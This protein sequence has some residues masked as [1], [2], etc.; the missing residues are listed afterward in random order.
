M[1]AMLWGACHLF[2]QAKN[3]PCLLLPLMLKV[4]WQLVRDVGEES[5]HHQSLQPSSR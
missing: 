3:V 4:D 2:V 1:R 5:P